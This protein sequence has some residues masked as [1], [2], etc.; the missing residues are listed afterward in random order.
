MNLLIDFDFWRKQFARYAEKGKALKD[1]GNMCKTCAFRLDSEA[2]LEE[3]T[4]ESVYLVMADETKD[5]VF[6]CHTKD[7][8]N[9][10][11][12]CKGWIHAKQYLKDKFKDDE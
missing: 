4:I 5:R 6:N 12:N 1:C 10:G 7:L 9:S 2:N 3:H 8:K 11:K